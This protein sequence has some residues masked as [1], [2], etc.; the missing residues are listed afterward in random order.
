MADEGLPEL[1]SLIIDDGED[2]DDG[3][4]GRGLDDDVADIIEGTLVRRAEAEVLL[5]LS[6][7]TGRRL[8]HQIRTV[9]SSEAL[10]SMLG[11]RG[12]HDTQFTVRV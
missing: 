2:E 12:F 11:K 6:A 9:V 3:G 7:R 5:R 10:A 1:A 8:A 4:G